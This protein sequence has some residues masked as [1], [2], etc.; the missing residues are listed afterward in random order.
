VARAAGIKGRYTKSYKQQKQGCFI[1]TAVYGSYEADEVLALRRFRDDILN[2]SMPGRAAIATYYFI[3]PSIARFIETKP[4]I[5]NLIR[6]LLT[7]FS[8]RFPEAQS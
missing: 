2:K 8:K 7:K 1:A 4:A 6:P 5:K 3:S